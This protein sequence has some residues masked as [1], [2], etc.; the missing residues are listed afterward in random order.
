MRLM[1]GFSNAEDIDAK[2]KNTGGWT[3]QND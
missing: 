2:R 3:E 1:G